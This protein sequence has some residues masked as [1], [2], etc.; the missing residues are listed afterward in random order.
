M[1]YTHALLGALEVRLRISSR[2]IFVVLGRFA[3]ALCCLEATLL[4]SYAVDERRVD[5][6]PCLHVLLHACRDAC[7]F[8]AGE[9]GAGLGNALLEAVLLDFLEVNKL[10]YGALGYERSS[11][12][13]SVSDIPQ[14]ACAGWQSE[15]PP[16]PS[17]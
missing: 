6:V 16:A 7:L 5:L 17:A 11:G 8:A 1:I 9:G 4:S 2:Y 12:S 14:G 3:F 13:V 10:A 15:P